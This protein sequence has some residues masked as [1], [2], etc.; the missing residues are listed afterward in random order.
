MVGKRETRRNT[1][2]RH[3]LAAIAWKRNDVTI[4]HRYVKSFK[5][6]QNLSQMV[7]IM[8]IIQY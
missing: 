8:N 6:S 3:A 4:G 5:I 7:H 2:I 1:E